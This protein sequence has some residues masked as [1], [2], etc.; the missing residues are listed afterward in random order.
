[1]CE[2]CHDTG[3]LNGVENTQTG[4]VL[5]VD[6]H[7]TTNLTTGEVV[8]YPQV[9]TPGETMRL[10]RYPHWTHFAQPCKCRQDDK[11]TALMESTARNIPDDV[12]HHTLADFKGIEHAEY[13]L[14]IV[15]AMIAGNQVAIGGYT[16]PGVTLSGNAGAGK[17]T[18]A[19]ILY[20]HYV[21]LGHSCAWINYNDLINS[22]RESYAEDYRGAPLKGIVAP[23]T[24]PQVLVLDNFGSA[25]RL[26]V[27][28]EDAIEGMRLLLE[29]R[30]NRNLTTITTTEL[31]D[32]QIN[33]QFGAMVYSR[34]MGGAHFADMRGVDMRSK[35]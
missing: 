25:T 3:Y 21:G 5:K 19:Y 7:H 1:M 34:L 13:A 24:T 20:R 16:K 9:L 33:H 8:E 32:A 29:P 6:L 26:T 12:K 15:A 30:Y 2:K 14:Q 17:S 18:L 23:Y 31:A 10:F 35:V 22:I 28:A 11:T 4:E 27:M